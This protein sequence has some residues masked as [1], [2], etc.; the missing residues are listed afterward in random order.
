MLY[1]AT[2]V[3]IKLNTKMKR[4]FTCC[5]ALV[6]LYTAKA[7]TPIYDSVSMNPGYANA[8]FYSLANGTLASAPIYAQADIQIRFENR[9]AS[10][11]TVDGFG[12]K[13]FLPVAH[14]LTDWTT[15]DTTA[16]IEQINSDTAWEN[17]S[18]NAT[19][20]GH[21]SYGWGT[22]DAVTHDINGDKIFVYQNAMG[23]FKKVQIIILNSLSKTYYIKHANL[24]GSMEYTDTI[25]TADFPN[26][27]FG[28]F[29]FF[30]RTKIDAEPIG[31]D[32]DLVF[33]K[34]NRT[35]DNY[36]VAG[37]L[38]NLNV[39]TAKLFT[40]TPNTASGSGLPYYTNMSVIGYDWKIFT[41]PTGPW[42]VIDSAAYFVLDQS[43]DIWR[44]VFTGF[45]GSATGKAYFTKTKV[46]S[47]GINTIPNEAI[48]LATMY[49]NPMA[50]DASISFTSKNE[51]ETS[52]EIYSA[53]GVL[54][55]SDNITAAAGLNLYQLNDLGLNNGIYFVHLNQGA[56]THTFKVIVSK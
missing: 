10:I 6:A 48:T 43:N 34:Y 51:A 38:S 1:F 18:F 44:I 12:A 40:H 4:I 3:H 55:Y 7:Q 49:P 39:L 45:G 11:R 20:T 27:N 15:L 9:S 37:V 16:M 41:P 26:K 2:F 46:G 19:A 52:I 54:A 23:A 42:A 56:E 28:Y 30:T 47:V 13:V 36:P 35:A 33:R 25:G 53:Q 17:G 31:T 21:P 8:V 22:Y 5:I 50:N 32:W 29:N 24:D 14:A